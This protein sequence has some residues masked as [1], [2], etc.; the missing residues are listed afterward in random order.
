MANQ[1]VETKVAAS[2]ATSVLTG[3]I[4][5]I[6]VTYVPVFHAGLPGPLATFLPWIISAV[7][8]TAAGYLAPHTSRTLPAPMILNKAVTAPPA[9]PVQ[10]P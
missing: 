4:T 1:P 9:G 6:L 10:D 7:T 2:S 8:A 5:W 3:V